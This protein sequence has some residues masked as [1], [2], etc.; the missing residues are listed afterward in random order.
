[1]I[2]LFRVMFWV[3]FHSLGKENFASIATAIVGVFPSEVTQALGNFTTS[4]VNGRRN[5]L[6]LG[7]LS[8]KKHNQPD[9][10]PIRGSDDGKKYYKVKSD[11]FIKLASLFHV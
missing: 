11:L 4:T 9:L 7:F 2:H 10:A 3:L 5:F 6:S 1:M 8:Q